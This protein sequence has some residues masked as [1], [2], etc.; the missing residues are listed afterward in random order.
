MGAVRLVCCFRRSTP[1]PSSEESV[2]GQP[3]NSAETPFAGLTPDRIL[4][5]LDSVGVRGDGRMLALNSYENRVYQVYLERGAASVL[6]DAG[7]SSIVVKFYRAGRWSDEAL[8]EEHGFVRELADAE[9]PV[10]APVALEGGRTWHRHQQFRFAIYPRR[11]GRA[12]ELEDADTLRWL[13]RFVGRIHE[14]GA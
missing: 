7:S 8:G 5:A 2:N 1:D 4:D 9:L 3:A 10:V 6:P 12:P 11:G 14:I 13:G